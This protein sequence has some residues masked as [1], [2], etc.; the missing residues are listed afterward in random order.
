MD[1]PA[2]TVEELKDKIVVRKPEDLTSALENI[3]IFGPSFAS[4][5]SLD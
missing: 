4:V 5:V 1:V 2:A 3:F